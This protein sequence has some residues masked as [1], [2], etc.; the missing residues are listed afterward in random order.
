M[1]MVL[2][3]RHQTIA[4]VLKWDESRPRPQQEKPLWVT[5]FIVHSW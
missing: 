5:L 2:R 1:F 3:D 4:I